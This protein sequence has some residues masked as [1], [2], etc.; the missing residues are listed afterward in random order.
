ME[1]QA[2]CAIAAAVITLGPVL[3]LIVAAPFVDWAH[4]RTEAL[5]GMGPLARTLDRYEEEGR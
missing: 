5:L 2:I 1:P 4:D 3:A